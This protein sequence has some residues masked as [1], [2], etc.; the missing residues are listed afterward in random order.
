MSDN[1]VFTKPVWDKN[2]SYNFIS[3]FDQSDIEHVL[4]VMNEIVVDNRYNSDAINQITEDVS[5]IYC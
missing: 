3:Q 1:I 5:N 4:S 2:S